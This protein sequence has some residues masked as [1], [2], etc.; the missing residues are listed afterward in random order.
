MDDGTLNLDRTIARINRSTDNGG[1]AHSTRD[2]NKRGRMKYPLAVGHYTF[3]D[4]APKDFS[5]NM[6]P[7]YDVRMFIGVA[8]RPLIYRAGDLSD[9]SWV[10]IVIRNR[11]LQWVDEY[12]YFQQVR[13]VM[14]NFCVHVRVNSHLLSAY[15][16]VNDA[17]VCQ[18]KRSMCYPIEQSSPFIAIDSKKINDNYP[19]NVEIGPP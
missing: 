18:F 1:T 13:L 11:C 12:G 5:L 15:A 8:C 7:G 14:E 3:G 16:Y 4:G 19:F 6:S 10:E 17:N 9:T 2:G